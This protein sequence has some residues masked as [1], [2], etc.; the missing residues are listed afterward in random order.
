MRGRVGDRHRDTIDEQ[1]VVRI[2]WLTGRSL[3][4]HGAQAVQIL[5]DD[6]LGHITGDIER[7]AAE[8]ADHGRDQ[9]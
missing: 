2:P 7:V 8:T 3:I 9:F 1:L 4:D 6:R 5:A